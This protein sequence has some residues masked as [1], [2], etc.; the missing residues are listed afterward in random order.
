MK[1][2]SIPEVRMLQHPFPVI[3]VKEGS[4][5]VLHLHYENEDKAFRHNIGYCFYEKSLV[6]LYLPENYTGENSLLQVFALVPVGQAKNATIYPMGSLFDLEEMNNVCVFRGERGIRSG[7]AL[8][9]PN[10]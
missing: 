3:M 1:E 5:N 10:R 6:F 7:F 9:R 8:I 2:H 4:S